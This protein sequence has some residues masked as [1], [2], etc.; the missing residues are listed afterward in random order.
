M[1]LLLLIFLK[2]S[3]SD[4]AGV[5]FE[6][7]GTASVSSVHLLSVGCDIFSVQMNGAELWDLIS[8]YPAAAAAGVHG[9]ASLGSSVQW[10]VDGWMGKY[11]YFIP[12]SYFK[13]SLKHCYRREIHDDQT[14]AL[15]CFLLTVATL[16][17][18]G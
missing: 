2:W 18:Q 12:L 16:L 15:S 3:E 7:C 5:R 1:L 14:T 8:F 13:H 17:E 10:T 9:P 6:W 11:E 4:C